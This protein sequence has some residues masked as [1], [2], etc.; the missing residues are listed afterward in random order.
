MKKKNKQNKTMPHSEGTIPHS[1]LIEHSIFL[2]ARPGIQVG[3]QLGMSQM[4]KVTN[5]TKAEKLK[6]KSGSSIWS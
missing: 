2:H 4:T 3:K 1:W 5:T 6:A